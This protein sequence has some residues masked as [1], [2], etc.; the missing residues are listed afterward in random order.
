MSARITI[1]N[2]GPI[3]DC[4]M[5]LEHFTVLTGK[6]AS[7][8][9]TVAKAIYF[10]RTIKDDICEDILKYNLLGNPSELT[11]VIRRT[12][13][14]KFLQMFGTSKAMSSD[15]KLRYDYS[16][17]TFVEI[18]LELREDEDF[19]N[20][21]YVFIKFSNNITDYICRRN[22]NNNSER[23]EIQSELN[24]LFSDDYNAVFIPAGR[25]LITLLTSQLNYL[26]ATMDDDQKRS[27][28]FCTQKYIER[29]LKI[30][31]LFND[32]L[33]GL[34]ELKSN[35][36]KL[37]KKAVS[38][39]LNRISKVLKGR[40]V[41]ANGEE[42]LYLTD[43]HDNTDRFVK[44]NYTSSGQQET[45]WLFN[46][47]FHILV[48][49]SKSFII[50]E[51]PEAHLYPDAQK[52]IS[53]IL[54]L[55]SNQSCELLITTHSPYILGAVNNL[56]YANGVCRDCNKTIINDL[57]DEKLHINNHNAYFV[58]KGT[59]HSCIE[60]PPER[61]IINEVI[62]GASSDINELYDRLFDIAISEE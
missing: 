41:F 4:T 21:K 46:I 47:L 37:D 6:Q 39:A 26:F 60:N 40:Y 25:S 16:D 51:E 29:I 10:F 61:L 9:S 32:G 57:V 42:R 53:E 48:T 30:R 56:I 11:T 2:L 44:I 20:P 52:D 7:G 24:D 12:L 38:M 55:M 62:D 31:P 59:I 54:A 36:I 35:M 58:D 22:K 1:H 50:L 19:I 13:R 43:N 18:T 15:M 27:I 5:D 45:V 34:A 28:D 49:N 3:N 17:D 23:N 14:N 8:K 33:D